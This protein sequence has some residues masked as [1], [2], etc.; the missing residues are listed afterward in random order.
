M[1]VRFLIPLMMPEDVRPVAWADWNRRLVRKP[2]LAK[3]QVT[4]D[5]LS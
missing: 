1:S 5:L 3:R 2:S 4:Y